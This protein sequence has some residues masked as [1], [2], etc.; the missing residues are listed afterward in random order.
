MQW[1]AKDRTGRFVA[2]QQAGAGQDYFCLECGG[3]VRCRAG[4]LRRVHFFHLNR[5]ASCR[6][7]GKS[8]EHLQVQLF[9][10]QSIGPA[11]IQLE[12]PFPSVARI[13]DVCWE[14]EKL[15][16]EVQCSPISAEE[17]RQRNADYG[18][19]GYEV[20]WIL[21][22]RSFNQQV[23]RAAE[24]FLRDLP[25]YYTD[26]DEEGRGGIY[27]Q[28]SQYRGARRTFYSPRLEIESKSPKR[29][30]GYPLYFQ[31]DYTD[32]RRTAPQDERVLA[33]EKL[34]DEQERPYLPWPRRLL[35]CVKDAYCAVLHSLLETFSR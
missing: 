13:A 18:S 1:V 30:R 32:L 28:Y 35:V 5:P 4:V 11:S 23:V 20:V 9:L 34:A 7:A 22:E 19:E 26:I 29:K 16:F 10:K 25:H 15:I 8:A 31:G 24:H 2:A 3:V 21:H 12:R 27:D 33:L 14:A 6:Q 17:V